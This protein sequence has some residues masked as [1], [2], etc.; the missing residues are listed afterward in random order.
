M[1]A[2][3]YDFAL[4]VL[5]A[6]FFILTKKIVTNPFRTFTSTGF[7]DESREVQN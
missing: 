3:D 2:Q 6:P 1:M 4:K 7:T 5:V